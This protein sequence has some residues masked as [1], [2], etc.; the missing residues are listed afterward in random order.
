MCPG[1]ARPIAGNLPSVVVAAEP[2]YTAA[3]AHAPPVYVQVQAPSP[4]RSGSSTAGCLIEVLG[5][6]LCFGGCV[7]GPPCLFAGII[8]FVIGFVV[9]RR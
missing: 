7:V 8:V 5:L 3:P 1:C 2:T 4:P 6:C 9:A